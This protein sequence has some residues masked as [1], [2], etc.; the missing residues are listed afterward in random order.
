MK[1]LIFQ[2]SPRRNGVTAQLIHELTKQL[3]GEVKIVDA[4]N[5]NINP[6]IDCRYCWKQNGCAQKD[7]M[8]GI[9]DYIEDCDNIIIASPIYFSEL[10][11]KLLSVGSRL[12]MYF[13]A[14]YFRKITMIT[15]RKYGAVILC[16]G[17]DGSPSK[18]EDT[19]LC[20]LKHMKAVSV[21]HVYTL[22]TNTLS[23]LGDESALI[24]IK[25]LATKLNR[26]NKES[27]DNSM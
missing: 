6:C 26:M 3:E 18:A 8:Q 4:Y 12:Q 11:G 5:D 14:E 9:Y 2:G 19:A 7:D 20:L 10:S 22:Q 15:K 27:M 23:D 21:G 1:T 17:G 25:E 16:G 24:E 13:A